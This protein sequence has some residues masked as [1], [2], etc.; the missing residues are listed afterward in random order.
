MAAGTPSTSSSVQSHWLWVLCLI[1]L[2]YFSTLAYQP[3]IAFETAGNAAPLATVAVVLITFLGAVPVYCYVAGRSPHGQG[4]LGLLER[5]VHG[6]FGKLLIVVLLG[7]A[8]TDFVITKTLS[9]ADA[10]EHLIHNP[11]PMWQNAL[12]S[13]GEADGPVKQLLPQLLWQKI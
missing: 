12:D 5:S 9:V 13:L 4:A 7:F 11:Q 10:A 8:A 6:W 1:G 2:D 3:S